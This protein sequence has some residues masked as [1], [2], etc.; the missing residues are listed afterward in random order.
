M[1]GEGL[2][3]I[4]IPCPQP[5]LELARGLALRNELVMPGWLN[6]CERMYEKSVV[7]VGEKGT[8]Y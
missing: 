4:S 8:G 7:W 6:K 2:S 1:D 5:S 3:A